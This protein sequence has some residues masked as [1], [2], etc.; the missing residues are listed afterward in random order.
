MVSVYNIYIDNKEKKQLP[1]NS[2]LQFFSLFTIE[3][4]SKRKSQLEERYKEY[5]YFT[6]YK[7][8]YDERLRWKSNIRSG[9]AEPYQKVSYFLK[10]RQTEIQNS[11]SVLQEVYNTISINM[12]KN[13]LIEDLLSN[14]QNDLYHKVNE[15]IIK[16]YKEQGDPYSYR[17]R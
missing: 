16:C 9:A 6:K 5:E 1:G 3:G 14:Y 4:L 12:K 7:N 13:L 10:R 11:K 17:D 15:I 2:T 8:F